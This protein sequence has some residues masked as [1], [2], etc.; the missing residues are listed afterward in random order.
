MTIQRHLRDTTLVLLAARA[1][2]HARPVALA[3]RTMVRTTVLLHLRKSLPH[4]QIG[5]QR[6]SFLN[7]GSQVRILPGVPA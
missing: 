7:R 2:A 3:M 4:R 5:K 1:R 6:S